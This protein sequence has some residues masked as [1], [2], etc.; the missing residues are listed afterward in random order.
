MK[1]LSDL[2]GSK[3]TLHMGR[4]KGL[5]SLQARLPFWDD[6]L[7][8]LLSSRGYRLT[9]RGPNRRVMA[10]ATHNLLKQ[11]TYYKLID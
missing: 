6:D 5:L 11:L 3:T 10:W 7:N 1:L 2:Q 4:V 9:L 8:L